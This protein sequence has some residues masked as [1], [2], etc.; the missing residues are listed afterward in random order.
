MFCV[1]CECK[2]QYWIRI[3]L[4]IIYNHTGA[5]IFGEVGSTKLGLLIPEL[6]PSLLGEEKS[7][8]ILSNPLVAMELELLGDL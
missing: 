8:P 2:Q 3:R 4:Y 6:F 1:R 5:F 7:V